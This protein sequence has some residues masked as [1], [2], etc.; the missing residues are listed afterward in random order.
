MSPAPAAAVEY[1]TLVLGNQLGQGGQG[2]VYQVTNKK[3]NKTAGGGWDV[4]YKEYSPPVLPELDAGALAAQVDLPGTLSAEDGAWL[5]DHTAW[6][7][8]VVRRNGR[9]CG[10]LMRLIPARFQFTFKSL[11]GTGTAVRKPA[12]LEYLL[13]PDAYVAGIGLSVSERDRVLLLA[14]LATTLDRLHGMGIAVG[15]LSPRNLLFTTAPEPGCFLI[16]CDAMRLRGGTALPQAET[17]DW[18]LPGG[19]EKATC[20]GDVYKFALLAVRLFARDQT[21]TDPVA[22]STLGPPLADLARA[23]LH[24]DPAQRPSPAIWAEQLTAAAPTASAAP[25]APAV[26]AAS[27][28]GLPGRPG[29]PRNPAPAGPV[30]MP[31][32]KVAALVLA[33]VVVLVVVL[34]ALAESGDGPSTTSSRSSAQPGVSASP[35][36]GWSDEPYEPPSDDPLAPEETEEQKESEEPESPS[37]SPDPVADAE[38]GSCFYDEGTDTTVD[39]REAECTTGAFEVVDLHHGTTDLDSCDDVENSDRSISSP[40]N[41]LVM[42]LSFL[43]ADGDA[44]H[45]DQGDCVYGRKAGAWDTQACETGNFKVLAVYNG[46]DTSKCDDW[47]RYN[48]WKKIDGPPDADRDVLL[49]LSM[50]YPDDIGYAEMD[51]CLLQRGSGDRTTHTNTGSCSTS[52]IVVSGRTPHYG[53][54]AF[55]RDNGWTTWQNPSFPDLAYTVCFRWK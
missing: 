36:D 30:N 52:N 47:P 11:T 7:A 37:A 38:V 44:Y 16:D 19:E 14:D 29:P 39:L 46:S 49:C 28:T 33:F 42:C 31:P 5:C 9:P 40:R 45:A 3:I 21:A 53:A 17:P 35:S 23:S 25:V 55:C 13:N 4:A 43:S 26:P 34:G 24:R 32:G 48:Y 1:S 41:D 6:P 12:N 15:D 54:A 20:A 50:N 2:T 8:A 27:T 18:Q 10:L 51:Q 22:L